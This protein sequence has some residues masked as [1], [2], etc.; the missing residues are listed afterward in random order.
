MIRTLLAH[1]F[2]PTSFWH[3][4]LQ[5]ATYLLNILPHK[6]LSHKSPTQI[7]YHRNPTY[8]HLRVFGCLCYPLFPSTSIHKLQH[9]TTPC[10]FLGYPSNH[11]GYKCYD[12]SNRKIIISRHVIFDE[13]QFPFAK[14]HL[15]SHTTYD[16]LDDTLHPFRVHH[17]KNQFLQPLATTP[18]T[19]PNISHVSPLVIQ[20]DP[21]PT[22]N[23][24]V[25]QP[26]RTITTRNMHG[27]SKPKRQLNLSVLANDLSPS[28]IPKNPKLALSDLH[29]KSAMQEE[30]DA[31]IKN[32]TWDLVPRPC[33]VNIIRSMWIF[34]HKK[35]SNGSFEC[36]KARLVG[37]GRSQKAGVDCDETFSPV[38]KPTTIRT[39]LSITL[40]NFWPIH[41][42]DV[43]NAFLHGKL[44]ETVY[45]HQ[46]MG[47]RDPTH[48]DYVCL[49]KKSLYGL[50]QALWAWYQRFAD[51]VSTIGFHHCKSDHSLFIYCKGTYMAYILLYVDDIILTTSTDDLRKSILRL[52]MNLQ[53]ETY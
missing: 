43:H 16:F 36:Y 8:T 45:M 19:P 6:S 26:A 49:L 48:P 5:M 50:K 33:D 4:A 46:L 27:I 30:F 31:L 52:I 53:L 3:H 42:S 10:V 18:T 25:N 7:L 28:P 2:M 47:F 12:L 35:K 34:R 21:P 37:D 38:V 39:V 44:H 22:N 13:T 9:R 41:Q 24:P 23:Q 14:L 29:W 32:K 51:Y 20:T 1:S 40:S 11:R 15:P 17:W